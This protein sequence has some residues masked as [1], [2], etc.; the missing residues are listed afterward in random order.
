MSGSAAMSTAIFSKFTTAMLK[1]TNWYAEVN[2][3]L[4]EIAN[5]GKNKGCGFLNGSTCE[6]LYKYEEFTP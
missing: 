3:E 6:D 1:D 2:D 4:A 5:Y